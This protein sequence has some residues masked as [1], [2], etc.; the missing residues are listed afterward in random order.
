MG[1]AD[2]EHRKKVKARNEKLKG[3]RK[4]NTEEFNRLLKEAYEKKQ[5]ED[6]NN[7]SVPRLNING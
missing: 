6:T 3:E 5:L 1:K 2:R 7:T 4:R